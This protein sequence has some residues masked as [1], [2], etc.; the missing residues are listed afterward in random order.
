MNNRNILFILSL[1]VLAGCST[2]PKTPDSTYILNTDLSDSYKNIKSALS[3]KRSKLLFD[4]GKA[5]NNC[6]RYFALHSKYT[7]DESLHNQQVKS[8]YLMC[9]A[10]KILSDSSGIS[11]IKPKPSSLGKVLLSKLDLRT[12]PSSLNR[13]CSKKPCTL[14]SLHSHHSSFSGN[15]AKYEDEDWVF[16]LEVVAVANLN[17]NSTPDWIVWVADESKAGNYK[18]YS[19]IILYDPDEK[20]LFKATTFP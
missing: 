11:S 13:L 10:L 2:M 6:H 14:K 1:C 5:A 7:L 8:E 19:T 18:G 3:Q 12:F 17:A 16:T 4:N 15:V 9:D 20:T